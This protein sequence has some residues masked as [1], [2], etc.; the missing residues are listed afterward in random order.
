METRPA[1]SRALRVYG[2]ALTRAGREDE[3][4]AALERSHAIA[5]ELGLRDRPVVA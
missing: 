1:L 4:R 5:A 2:D 3:G